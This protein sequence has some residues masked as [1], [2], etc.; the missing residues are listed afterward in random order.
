M[1]QSVQHHCL[2]VEN[3][4]HAAMQLDYCLDSNSVLR[5]ERKQGFTLNGL[6]FFFFFFTVN[7]LKTSQKDRG[8][9][10]RRARQSR[11]QM[12]LLHF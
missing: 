10:R 9:F 3:C 8:K 6:F 11:M 7:Q 5:L 1:L 12:L 2:S 4:T